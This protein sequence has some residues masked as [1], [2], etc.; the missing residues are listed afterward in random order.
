MRAAIRVAA[1]LALFARMGFGQGSVLLV[2]G[3]SEDYNDWSDAPYRWLVQH[4]PNGHILVLHY[5]TAS[6]FLPGYFQ[7]LGA[8]SATNLIIPSSVSANDTNTAKAILAC[9]GIFLRGGDQ[10]QYIS[11]WRGTLAETALRQ[12]FQRGGVIGGTSAGMA[13]LSQVI[14]DAR[15]TSVD[16]RDALRNP[17]SSGMSFT[18]NFLGFVPG[19]L[20]D[21]HF[22][23][24]G[25]LGRLMAMLCVYR[26]QNGRWITG[27]GVDY[28]TALAVDSSGEAQVMG[29]GTVTVLRATAG[30]TYSIAPG[31]PL[32]MSNLRMDM[33]TSG[34]Q[35]NL[36]SGEILPPATARPF[37]PDEVHLSAS[38]LILDGSGSA[39]VWTGAAGSL[40]HFVGALSS[41]GDTVGVISRAGST[42]GPASVG[43]FLSARG[44]AW[45]Q[46]GVSDGT[47][48][49]PG[50][51]SLCGRCRGFVFVSNSAESLAGFFTSTLLGASFSRQLQNNSPVLMLSSDCS[52]AADTAVG[53]IESDADGAYYGTLTLQKG[54]GLVRGIEIMP[55]IYENPDSIDNRFSG[56][57]WGLGKS[58]ASYGLLLDGGTYAGVSS[59]GILSISGATPAIVV[60]ARGVTSLDFPSFRASVRYNPRA[61][62][63]LVGA[64]LHVVRDAQSFDFASGEPLGVRSVLPA[65]S[66]DFFLS[67]SYPNPFNPATRLQ[68]RIARHQPVRLSVYDLT[69]K[70][71][72]TLLDRPVDPGTYSVTFDGSGLASGVYFCR[73][74]SPLYAQTRKLILIR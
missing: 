63:A 1:A 64:A 58:R 19:V 45:R 22:F 33:L 60:D 70:E 69:G 21:T 14:V 17:L 13:V 26:E 72:A 24:R 8:A 43:A 12:V 10:W 62:A 67:Q 49:D 71:I 65:P 55:R 3:G 74:V 73:L 30:T 41:P 38:P 37:S 57:F 28:S 7:W 29:A 51:A 54:L 52:L 11:L 4:A 42:S 18:E 20:G 27:V 36:S 31:S 23:E 68:F 56:L 2:G 46:L 44:V 32:A 15:I 9:D 40:N 66:E 48:N 6:T 53:G 59:A 39:A 5:S 61:G 35:V 25:R 50:L 16:P 34:Y 47:K